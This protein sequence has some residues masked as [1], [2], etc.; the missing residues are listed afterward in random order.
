MDVFLI[1]F[2][3]FILFKIISFTLN[4]FILL[5]KVMMFTFNNLK[6]KLLQKNLN[7]QP[8]KK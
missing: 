5:K 8:I 2:Y 3:Y 6:D 7:N 4:I 1:A